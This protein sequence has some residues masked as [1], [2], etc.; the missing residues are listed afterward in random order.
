[1][2]EITSVKLEGTTIVPNKGLIPLNHFATPEYL[3]GQQDSPRPEDHGAFLL[4]KD[5]SKSEIQFEPKVEEP[6]LAEKEIIPFQGIQERLKARRSS[7]INEGLDEEPSE[8][9]R[10]PKLLSPTMSADSGVHSEVM[11][12]PTSRKTSQNGQET[13][14]ITPTEACDKL[15]ASQA[16]IE[17]LQG[18]LPR[19]YKSKR[20]K[21]PKALEL[22]TASSDEL[23]A[24][25]KGLKGKSPLERI[26]E[27]VKELNTVLQD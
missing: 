26:H 23:E 21:R 14:T 25:L 9:A 17:E 5:P 2:G 10:A 27:Y 24:M 7:Q 18:S 1:M 8:M 6:A 16:K 20:P 22:Q 12:P 4:K 13:G 19:S 15:F 11:S 3:S